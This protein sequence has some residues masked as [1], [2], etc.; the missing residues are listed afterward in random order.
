MPY[1]P[2]ESTAIKMVGE[3]VPMPYTD[4]TTASPILESL[5]ISY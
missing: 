5:A 1:I 3:Y 4:N 2:I